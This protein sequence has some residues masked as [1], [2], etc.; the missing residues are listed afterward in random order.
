MLGPH[1][2][3]VDAVKRSGPS[4]PAEEQGFGHWRDWWAGMLVGP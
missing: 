1:G 3:K 2:V 4:Q